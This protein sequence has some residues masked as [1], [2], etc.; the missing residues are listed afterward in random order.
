LVKIGGNYR[1]AGLLVG[2]ERP[3]GIS[4]AVS[5]KALPMLD[6]AGRRP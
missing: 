5:M 4:V 1:V 2:V 6:F 3:S